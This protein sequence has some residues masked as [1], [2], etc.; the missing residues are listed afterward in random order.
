METAT[1][2]IAL[3]Y[4]ETPWS[5]QP[6][7]KQTTSILLV[8]DQPLLQK[9][10]QF[11]LEKLDCHVTI[12]ENGKAVWRYLN[13]RQ[14]FDLILMD[15]KLPDIDGI[16]LTKELRKQCVQ[17]PIIAL[18]SEPDTLK[19]RAACFAAGMNDFLQKP[20][21]MVMLREKLKEWA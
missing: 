20:V 3:N 16:T 6:P 12:A 15:L 19:L 14:R 13:A 17:V 21:T 5:S 7:D 2:K 1:A 8:E 11:L 18:T 4:G 9:I 10:T